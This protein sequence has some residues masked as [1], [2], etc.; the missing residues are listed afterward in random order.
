M[1]L[2]HWCLELQLQRHLDITR[3]VRLA[4]DGAEVR[5]AEGGVRYA[6]LHFIQQV[7]G[8]QAE[9]QVKALVD[10]EL[11]QQRQVILESG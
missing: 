8:F 3:L 10:R 2:H 9:L 4:G 6:E 1:G 5:G 7:E 11:F